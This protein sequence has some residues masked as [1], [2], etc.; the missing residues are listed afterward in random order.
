MS[1]IVV[2]RI[3]KP[4]TFKQRYLLASIKSSGP[5]GKVTAMRWAP[6]SYMP[7]Y[8]DAPLGINMHTMRSLIC[9]GLVERT[10]GGFYKITDL[11]RMECDTPLPERDANDVAYQQRQ[12][13]L[14]DENDR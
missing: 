8:G 4:L 6:P 9:R 5:S 3:P 2:K 13:A 12:K 11:G 14:Q 1:R 7:F 10:F